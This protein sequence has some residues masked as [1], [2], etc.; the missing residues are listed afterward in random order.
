MKTRPIL[1]GGKPLL[2]WSLIAC[3]ILTAFLTGAG[4][5]TTVTR[6]NYRLFV[7]GCNAT[8]AD[9]SST[10]PTSVI[11]QAVFKRNITN[12]ND[13]NDSEE[14]AKALGASFNLLAAPATQT[15]VNVGGG[16]TVTDAQL[17][18]LIRKRSETAA[19]L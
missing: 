17:A 14:S 16:V 8:Y 3:A 11:C 13:A 2:A 18:A 1:R 9:A 7:F 19:G 6:Q 10:T 4:A 5:Q 15:T 12:P